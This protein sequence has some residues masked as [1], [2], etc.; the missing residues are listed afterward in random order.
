MVTRS[1]F[2]VDISP[3]NP[4]GIADVRVMENWF[5]GPTISSRD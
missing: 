4:Y 1:G 2:L 5:G 3:S